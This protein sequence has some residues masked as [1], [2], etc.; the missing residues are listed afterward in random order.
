VLDALRVLNKEF[1]TTVVIV[2]HDP[3]IAEMVDR[4]VHIIDGKLEG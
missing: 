4:T 3:A 1:G 2:T